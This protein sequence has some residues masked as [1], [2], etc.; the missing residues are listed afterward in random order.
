M[1]AVEVSGA[2]S[3]SDGSDPTETASECA[4]AARRCDSGAAQCESR[5]RPCAM[6]SFDP[7]P[8]VRV[9]SA[10]AGRRGRRWAATLDGAIGRRVGSRWGMG[11]QRTRP[12]PILSQKAGALMRSGLGRI[13]Q[14]SALKS[15]MERLLSTWMNSSCGTS[16]LVGWHAMVHVLRLTD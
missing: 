12:D 6:G 16:V 8:A 14:C 13:V 7:C 4:A 15:P 9:C 1:P 3:M 11:M 2:D 5:S 10:S